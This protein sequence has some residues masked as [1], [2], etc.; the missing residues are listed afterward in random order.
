MKW[1]KIQSVQLN[2]S[3]YQRQ[4]KVATLKMFTAGGSII[5]PFIQ[6]REAFSIYNYILYK[7]ESENQAWM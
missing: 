7:T 3:I 6:E 5:I 2:Q 4:K 1:H